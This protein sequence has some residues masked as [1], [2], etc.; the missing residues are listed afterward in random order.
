G[1]DAEVAVGG[2]EQPFQLREG[3]RL[4]DG[5]RAQDAQSQA[6]MNQTIEFGRAERSRYPRGGLFFFFSPFSFLAAFFSPAI[7]HRNDSTKYNVQTAESG[8]QKEIA[9]G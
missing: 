2:V 4:V 3:Q 7:F 5:K 1:V 8:S 6:L 9:R